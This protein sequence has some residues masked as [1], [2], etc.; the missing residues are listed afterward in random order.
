MTNKNTGNTGDTAVKPRILYEDNHL[1]I[2]N[3]LTSELVQ[4]DKTGDKTLGDSV[5]DY[6]KITY[7]KPG[8]VFLGT[9]HRLDRP[10]SGAVVFA[11]TSKALSRLNNMF[12]D[13]EVK[14]IYWAVTD[15]MPPDEHG[16]L[17]HFLLR[18]QK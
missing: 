3:K 10:T 4:G 2:V 5:S 1:I 8:N 16:V 17:E 13:N 18:N 9:V 11:K 14:K 15:A 7:N 12:R 6:I